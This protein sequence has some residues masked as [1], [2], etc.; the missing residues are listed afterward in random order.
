VNGSERDVLG[1]LHTSAGFVFVCVCVLYDGLVIM[2]VPMGLHA[3]ASMLQGDAT[4][5]QLVN[6]VPLN[7][8]VIFLA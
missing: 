3:S 7:R 6:S 5:R 1:R 2:V 4:W 8:A